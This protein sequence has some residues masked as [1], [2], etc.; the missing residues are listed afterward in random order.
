VVST[1]SESLK[2]FKSNVFGL[3]DLTDLMDFGRAL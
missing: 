1:S 3:D 2:V